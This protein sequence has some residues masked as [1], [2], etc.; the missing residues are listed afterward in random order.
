MLALVN[1]PSGEHPAQLREVPEPSAAPDEAIVE[2]RA[3]SLNRGELSLLASRPEGWRPGQDVSGVVA[4]AARSGGG[5]PEGARVMGLVDEAGWAE[6]VAVP[7]SSLAVLPDGVGFVEAATLPIAGL[8]ALRALGRGG[9]LLGA[10]VLVTGATGGVGHLAVQLAAASGASVTAV[11]SGRGE[12]LL[13]EFGAA[14]EVVADAGDAGGQFG[15]ILESVGGPSL[16]AAVRRLAPGGTL[17][18]FGNSS[19]RRAGFDFFDFFE[20]YPQGARIEVFFFASGTSTA[21][22]DLAVLG[23][24]VAAGKLV[25]KV[26]WEGSWKDVARGVEALRGRRVAGKAVFRV[27]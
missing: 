6:R 23:S 18:V 1:T 14:A 26:G 4:R 13:E 12:G 25:P 27:D 21:A 15:L 2:V 7:V 3:F 10:R 20:L 22:D 16:D 5:P 19:Q 11:A 17:V 24:L 9:Q 8:T